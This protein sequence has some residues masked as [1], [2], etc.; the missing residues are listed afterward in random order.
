MDPRIVNLARRL[1]PDQ[2]MTIPAGEL[3]PLG[4]HSEDEARL[5]RIRAEHDGPHGS[6]GHG[7]ACDTC[8]LIAK[9]DW[10]LNP[11]A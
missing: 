7:A 3:A 4:L 6:G 8:W 9:I 1:R 10:F 11:F 2:T 5:T